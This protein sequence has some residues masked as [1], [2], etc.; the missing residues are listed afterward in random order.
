MVQNVFEIKISISKKSFIFFLGHIRL[1]KHG[2]YVEKMATQF[3]KKISLIGIDKE[4][5]KLNLKR[6][7]DFENVFPREFF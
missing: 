7:L 3:L 4:W 1:E 5:P 6:N 2:S